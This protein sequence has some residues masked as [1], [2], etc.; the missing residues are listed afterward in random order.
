M[1]NATLALMCVEGL[2]PRSYKMLCDAFGSAEAALEQDRAALLRVAGISAAMAD[3]IV[4]KSYRESRDRQLEWAGKHGA[5]IVCM[6]EEAYPEA[7]RHIYGA[8]PLLMYKGR[9]TKRDR[10]AIAVVGTR[11]PDEYGKR[12]TEKITRGIARRGL[13][14]VSGMARGIDTLAHCS[15]LRQGARSIAVLGTPLDR[16]YPAENRGVFREICRNGAVCSENLIG[17]RIL[18]GNFVRRNRIISGLS[19]GVVVTQA[20]TRSGA[21]V[22][23]LNANEQNRDVFAVPGNCLKGYHTGCHR[24]IRLG[25]KIVERAEDVLNEYPFIKERGQMELL[26]THASGKDLDGGAKKV[27]GLIGDEAVHIDVLL[28]KSGI[29]RP[30]ILR[31]LLDLEIR[32]YIRTRPGNYYLRCED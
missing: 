28:E 25:A 21:L 9:F 6:H 15:A 16:I 23:A 22:T 18:P 32:G 11:H 26:S 12:V 24:L 30:E 2:G 17:E 27:L 8:P 3:A 4:K 7:L 20:G 13:T 31:A 10:D 5:R 14:V 19:R 1:E 29:P